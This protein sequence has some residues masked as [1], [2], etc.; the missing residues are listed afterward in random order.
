MA[1]ESGN[2]STHHR[3]SIS[4]LTALTELHS[5]CY[6]KVTGQGSINR[7]FL[8]PYPN[9]TILSAILIGVHFEVQAR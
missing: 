3:T 9:R 5:A 7:T 1:F 2:A 8:V 4:C 6:P